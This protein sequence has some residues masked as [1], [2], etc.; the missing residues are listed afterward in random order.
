M[1]R[2]L[3]LVLILLLALTAGL[4]QSAP[5]ADSSAFLA[6]VAADETAGLLTQEEALVLKF[7]YAFEADRLPADYQV[8]GFSPLKCA[9]PMVWEYYEI[10]DSLTEATR[11]LIDG[12]LTLPDDGTRDNYLSPSGRFSLTYYT[13]GTNAVPTA[14]VDPPNGIPD[15]VERIAEYFDYTWEVET[16]DHSF[17]QPPIGAGTYPISFESMGP[18]GYTQ[19][20]NYS[21][22]MTRIVMH[23]TFLGFPPND[24]PDGNQLGAAKV[25]AA[26]EFKHATQFANTRWAEGGWNEMDATWAEE[27]VYDETNDYYNYLNGQSPIRYPE[28]ALDGGPTGTGSYE[29]CVFELWLSESRGVEVIEDYWQW[30]RNHTSQDVMESWT[31]VMSDHGLP[32]PEGW[33]EF[34][35]WNYGTGYRAIAGVGYDEAADYP[36]GSST[37][38]TSSYPFSY[39]GSVNRLAA[40]FI[41]LLGFNGTAGGLRVNF[42]GAN[43]G[44]PMSASVHIKKNDGTGVIETIPLDENNDAVY[45]VSVPLADIDLAGVI[46]GN[47]SLTGSYRSYSLTVD[48]SPYVPVPEFTVDTES[49]AV[50]LDANE[51]TTAYVTIGNEGEAESVL[52]F[53]VQIWGHDPTTLTGDKS[54]SGTTLTTNFEHY[55]PGSSMALEFTVTNGSTDEEWLTD[56]SANFPLGAVVTGSTDFVGGSLGDLETAGETGDGAHVHWHGTTGTPEYG[57][58]KGGESATATVFIDVDPSYSGNMYINCLITGDGEGGTPHAI[59]ASILL[60]EGSPDLIVSA[61]NGG[62]VLTAGTTTAVAWST[63]GPVDTVMIEL[64]RDGGSTWETVVESVANTGSYEMAVTGPGTSHALIRV[65]DTDSD[66]SDESDAEFSILVAVEWLTCSPLTGSVPQ[67]DTQAL[68]LG[69]SAA[70]QSS[71]AHTAWLVI[72][73]N[74]AGPDAVIPVTMTVEGGVAGTG[75][76]GVFALNGNYPNP[77]NPKT[78]ISFNL[79]ARADA[80]VDVLDVR[81]HLVRRLYS[82]VLEAGAQSVQWDGMDDGGRTVAAGIYLARLTTT[83][84]QATSKMT[85]AK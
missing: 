46:V 41:R 31:Q 13:T 6:K 22:G 36:Y 44:G 20:T 18:Y 58:I 69:I 71:G 19:P 45:I 82:G 27:L 40:N 56:V 42:N 32:F 76:P 51:S 26:H 52:D 48:W 23:N 77:F 30:R 68:E 70:G 72:N 64:S 59:P 8:E 61:P 50:S 83:G 65:S 35:A 16:V 85:L 67:G 49:V 25:T 75:V 21:T 10:R 79:P 17:T 24:D 78:T 14:D 15:Y 55:V 39:N 37:A 34:T 47:A 63:L 74:G 3:S 84:Y 66:L 43:T 1:T 29:D 73:H 38:Y 80:V 28:I 57:V 12:Y 9:T 62:E 81:G 7:Q 60:T 33:A 5:L 4:V 53:D 54:I 2:W 11:E